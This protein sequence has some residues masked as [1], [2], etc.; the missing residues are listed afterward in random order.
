M[1][2]V[3]QSLEQARKMQPLFERRAALLSELAA[4]DAEIDAIT[5]AVPPPQVTKK[6]RQSPH[7][8]QQP[9]VDCG[10]RDGDLD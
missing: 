2:N 1:N 9:T 7:T 10:G 6:G 5:T 3:K 4:L 8:A